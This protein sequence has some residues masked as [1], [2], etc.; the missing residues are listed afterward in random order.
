MAR[1][2][3]EVSREEAR[4]SVGSVSYVEQNALVTYDGLRVH[5]LTRRVAFYRAE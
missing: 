1:E 5:V 4:L 3:W 2:S